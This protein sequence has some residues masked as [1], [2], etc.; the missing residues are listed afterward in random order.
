MIG[1]ALNATPEQTLTQVLTSGEYAIWAA[2]PVEE[3]HAKLRGRF[4]RS[5]THAPDED[6]PIAIAKVAFPDRQ[7][8]CIDGNARGRGVVRD[9]LLCLLSGS[10]DRSLEVIEHRLNSL[11]PAGPSWQ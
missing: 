6:R 7:M 4:P 11:S 1:R 10:G 2:P 8:A 9:D 5:L 3:V